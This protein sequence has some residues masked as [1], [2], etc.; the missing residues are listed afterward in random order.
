MIVDDDPDIRFVIGRKL[1]KGGYDFIEA[2]N[3][4]EALEKLKDNRPD[5]I[6]LGL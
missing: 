5:L 1:K 4:I 6:L 2:S 3:G